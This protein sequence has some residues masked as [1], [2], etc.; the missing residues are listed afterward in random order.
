MQRIAQYV[1]CLGM[2][3]W[4]AVASAQG[5]EL[6]RLAHYGFE[7]DASDSTGQQSPFELLWNADIS[8]GVLC[9]GPAYQ[10]EAKTPLLNG[11]SYRSFTVAVDFYLREFQPFG[12]LIL[13][14]GPSY[15]WF[16]LET[17]NDVL[18][19]RFDTKNGE[20]LMG[21]ENVRVTTNQWYQAVVS[22]DLDTGLAQI[23]LN[24]VLVLERNIG[25]NAEFNVVG[26][27]SEPWDKVFSFRNYGDASTLVGCADNLQVYNR[28]ATPAEV[29][30]IIAPRL[31]IGTSGGVALVSAPSIL[32]GYQ[33]E[34]TDGL[35]AV[36]VWRSV[37]QAPV[38]VGDQFVWPFPPP[39]SGPA[40]R[41]FRLVRR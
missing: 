28:A 19:A 14:G 34:S 29:A 26:T 10:S 2:A 9:L 38:T 3:A 27:A 7:A 22:A 31:R 25:R 5:A 15:R 1:G 32:T 16:T 21:S 23:Y 4:L 17:W 33:L 8:N 41:M 39:P 24:G 30:G 20:K 11:F 40:H 35:G 12:N 18:V 36:L 37:T 13:S 6:V